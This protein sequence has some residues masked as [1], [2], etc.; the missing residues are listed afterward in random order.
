MSSQKQETVRRLAAPDIRSRKGGEPI[1]CLTAY[2]APTAALLDDHC[3]LLLVG[4]SVGSSEGPHGRSHTFSA[5]A[6]FDSLQC[7]QS[8]P[9]FGSEQSTHSRNQCPGPTA[10]ETNRASPSGSE[11]ETVATP[12]TR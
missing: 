3:D 7:G 5:S 6:S 12:P 9:Q 8:N 10:Q 1:V 11:T 4:D 2:D